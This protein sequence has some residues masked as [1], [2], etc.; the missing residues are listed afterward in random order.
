MLT[1]FE[2]YFFLCVRNYMRYVLTIYRSVEQDMKKR[3]EQLEYK[4]KMR[5]MKK[6]QK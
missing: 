6:T 5:Q 1:K 3:C 2:L 4:R